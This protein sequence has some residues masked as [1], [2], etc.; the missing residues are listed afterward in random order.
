MSE[1]LGSLYVTRHGAALQERTDAASLAHLS[2]EDFK[3]MIRKLNMR[4]GLTEA[5]R[6]LHADQLGRFLATETRGETPVVV[7]GP[8]RRHQETA[9]GAWPHL[10]DV[11]LLTEEGLAERSRGRV[12]ASVMR[13]AIMKTEMPAEHQAKTERPATWRPGQTGYPDRPG[14]WGEDYPMVNARVKRVFDKINARRAAGQPAIFF[15]SGEVSLASMHVSGFG[16]LIDA[17]FREGITTP[18]G[19]HVSGTTFEHGGVVAYHDPNGEG[20]YTHMQIM[21]PDWA[22]ERPYE[23]GSAIRTDLIPI[24][25]DRQ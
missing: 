13:A 5:G 16:G 21:Q 7:A 2:D 23:D 24:D 20:R 15:T 6:E 10:P 17:D 12:D 8:Y 19:L 14:A 25:R 3:A 9:R 4:Q 1:R 18:S 11:P 22:A